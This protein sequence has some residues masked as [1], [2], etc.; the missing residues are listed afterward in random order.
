MMSFLKILLSSLIFNS[1]LLLPKKV[2]FTPQR[3]VLERGPVANS[4][5]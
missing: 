4:E 3:G 1:G 2:D 5:A